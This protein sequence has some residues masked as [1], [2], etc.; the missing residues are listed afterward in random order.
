MV[1]TT[2][3][4]LVTGPARKDPGQLAGRT[5][6]N[7]VVN[8][9][10]GREMHRDSSSTSTI[11][12]AMTN[13]LRG[14]GHRKLHLTARRRAI[15]ATCPSRIAPQFDGPAESR[16]ALTT[17]VTLEPNDSRRLASLCGPFDQNLKYIERRM[18][19]RIRNRGN[20]FQIS[21][22]AQR[23]EASEA[24]L[25]ALYEDIVDG[26]GARFRGDSPA[27][28]GIRRRSDAPGG[29]DDGGLLIHTRR[30]T[31]KPRGANQIDLRSLDSAA[32]RRSSASARPVPARPTSPSRARSPRSRSS[33]WSDS[34]GAS[35]GRSRRK[36]RLSAGR[37]RAEDR[38]VPAPAVRRAC[39]K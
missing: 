5:E 2:Q 1:G 30:K 18:S 37:S 24:L 34:A 39:T 26:D 17:N 3:R 33:A 8:F 25:K 31:I 29:A 28:A 16:V 22:P 9:I 7:R 27:S 4:V 20:E 38:S 6:N 35:G 19:V 36:A 11:T 32:R 21:G 12:E 14:G 23:V 10:G 15:N 13:T